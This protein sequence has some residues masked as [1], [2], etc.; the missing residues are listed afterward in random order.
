MN[1]EDNEEI[2]YQGYRI[3]MSN[4]LNKPFFYNIKTKIGQFDKPRDIIFPP[5][6][7]D[8]NSLHD[9]NNN[10]FN[11]SQKSQNSQSSIL[12]NSN[13]CESQQLL[14]HTQTSQAEIINNQTNNSPSSEFNNFYSRDSQQSNNDEKIC[15]NTMN[16]INSNN[17]SKYF[18]LDLSNT[19]NSISSSSN[20]KYK[21]SQQ[22]SI[23][24]SQSPFT[25]LIDSQRVGSPIVSIPFKFDISPPN[26]YI[27]IDD[28]RDLKR[29]KSKS[30]DDLIEENIGNNK[31]SKSYD[32]LIEENIDDNKW[33]CSR[34]TLINEIST[35]TCSACCNKIPEV[36]SQYSILSK[37]RNGTSKKN[38]QKSTQN[39][40]KKR[41]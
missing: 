21:E 9:N 10:E 39:S 6:T 19:I 2:S 11:L 12:T 41:K 20:C 16:T 23:I 3:I 17:E 4:V 32:D 38:S 22:D 29:K 25:S 33:T 26:E 31:K 8:N 15:F 37:L 34:C 40:V 27:S 36:Y 24:D 13:K 28:N 30:Q 14:S 35:I 5:L 1:G 18:D 7:L